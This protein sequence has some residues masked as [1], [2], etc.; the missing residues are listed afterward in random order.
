MIDH[1]TNRIVPLVLTFTVS[2]L[3][4]T[5]LQF[6]MNRESPTSAVKSVD[7]L[8]GSEPV[9]RGSGSAFCSGMSREERFEEPIRKETGGPVTPYRITFQPKAIYT[10]AAR[11]NNV[12]GGVRLKI[13]LLANGQIGSVTSI[14][15]LPDGLT[16]QAIAAAKQ[17]KFEPKRVN[18]V[19]V[20]V[21]VTREYTFTIY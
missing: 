5:A 9:D 20:S 1:L 6:P 8:H 17:I 7:H 19:P 21:I 14:T 11:E 3:L 16:E 12:Q 13:V 15:E 10:D 18:G 4:T 2:V